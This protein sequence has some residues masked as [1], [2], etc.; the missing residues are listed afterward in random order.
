MT[1]PVHSME[2]IER[3]RRRDDHMVVWQGKSLESL[4]WTQS[5]QEVSKCQ[6]R[7]RESKSEQREEG[8]YRC[9][10]L[11]CSNHGRGSGD[12]IVEDKD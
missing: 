9:W 3:Q 1:N 12:G 6:E 10:C 4:S 2:T 11:G 5:W 8:W 7:E